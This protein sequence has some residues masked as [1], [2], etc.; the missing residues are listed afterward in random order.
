MGVSVCRGRG[1]TALGRG[2]NTPGYLTPG[3]QAAR[4]VWGGA[5]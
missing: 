5:R 3:G 2:Q 4:V 1:G